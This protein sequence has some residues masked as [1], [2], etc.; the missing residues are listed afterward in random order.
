MYQIKLSFAPIE[1][2]AYFKMPDWIP[3]DLSEMP[4]E[5]EDDPPDV[6]ALKVCLC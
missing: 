3:K 1:L 6:K 4:K 5:T 2:Q